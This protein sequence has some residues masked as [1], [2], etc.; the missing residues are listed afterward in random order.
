MDRFYI[1]EV[2][3]SNFKVKTYVLVDKTTGVNYLFTKAGYGAGLTALVDEN[4][5]PI[6]IKENE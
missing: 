6:V 3:G 1:K 2:C 4:G 5:L